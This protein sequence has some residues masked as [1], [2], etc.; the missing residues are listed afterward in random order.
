MKRLVLATHNKHKADEI[1][2]LLSDL[3]V[4]VLTLDSFPAVGEIA[5]DAE[6]IEG[7]SLLKAGA[8]F[9]A[10]GLPSLAD[11]T[12]LEVYY[13]A[14][15]PGV[16]SS[17]YAGE[18]ATYA[19]NVAKLLK[20]MQGVPPRRRGARFRCVLTFLAPRNQPVTAEEVCRGTIITEPR[21]TG[22]F[23]YDP[24]FLPLDSAKTFA[25]LDPMAKNAL[26]HRGKAIAAILPALRDY[27]K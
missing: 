4:E 5:E 3:S 15:A 7:N 21:G 26:S 14:L 17:R 22:G 10:T 1:R 8:V 9:R 12:G 13:L 23:G 2:A 18:T 25:E 24:V 20:E 19:D 6:T 27:F 11:D 16:R